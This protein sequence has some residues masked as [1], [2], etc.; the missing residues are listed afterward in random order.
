M[1]ATRY[2]GGVVS[3][4]MP[5]LGFLLMLTASGLAAA[6]GVDAVPVP[7]PP[8]APPPVPASAPSW[9]EQ[10]T[11]APGPPRAIGDYSAGC[12]Q[13]AR[14]L[15]LHA[16]GYQVMHPSRLRYFGHP[17][18]LGFVQGLGLAAHAQGLGP[19]LVGDM[20][21]PRGGRAP[22]G[23]AS[24]QTGLDVDLWYWLP[25]AAAKRVL[26]A[27]EVEA[28]SARSVLDGKAGGIAADWAARVEALLRITVADERVTR[29]FVHPLIK[30]ELCAHATGDRSWLSKLRPWYGHDDHFH[31][32][33]ACPKGSA[34]CTP[35]EAP[36][37]GD[38]CTELD[39]WLGDAARLAREQGRKQ[40][41]G[42]VAH[43]SEL[44]AACKALLL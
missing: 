28:T 39:Y 19:V 37:P 18:L 8:P 40:Y 11:P 41:E 44:P 1:G 16:E 30:Q 14:A 9:H 24:H 32:R 5:V 34:L 31:V 17:D 38:G 35:Q 25:K 21:Q 15:A 6:D 22:G 20:S 23:H 2:P 27:T 13:G 42:K 36:P 43:A 12:L 4:R 33:L 7:V 26:S 3:H 29:V 10:K